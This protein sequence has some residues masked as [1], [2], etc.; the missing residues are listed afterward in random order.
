[1][2]VSWLLRAPRSSLSPRRSLTFCAEGRP[3]AQHP[4]IEQH[5]VLQRHRSDAAR[6]L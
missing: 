2:I 5:F 1:M 6:G 3:A 4:K